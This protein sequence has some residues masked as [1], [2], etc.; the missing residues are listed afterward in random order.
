MPHAPCTVTWRRTRPSVSVAWTT[1]DPPPGRAAYWTLP[2]FNPCPPWLTPGLG[3]APEAAVVA[4]NTATTPTAR[5]NRIRLRI[6][7]P[8]WVPG[9]STPVGGPEVPCQA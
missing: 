7:P 4:P 5:T 9:A 6:V 3:P 2:L 8:P 1:V